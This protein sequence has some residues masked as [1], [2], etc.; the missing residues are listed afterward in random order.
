MAAHSSA[1]TPSRSGILIGVLVGVLAL[2]LLVLVGLAVAWLPRLENY[3]RSTPLG[4]PVVKGRAYEY[5]LTAPSDAWRLMRE[6]EARKHNERADRWLV[7]PD[8]DAHLLVVGLRAT[9]PAQRWDV[10]KAIELEVDA[11]RN[12][13]AKVEVLERAALES[14]LEDARLVHYRSEQ[15]RNRF[16]YVHAIF[17]AGE[18]MI[19]VVGWTWQKRFSEVEP[20]LRAAIAS[21]KLAQTPY[22]RARNRMSR[23]VRS[24]PELKA[25]DQQVAA[26]GEDASGAGQELVEKGLERLGPEHVERRL[27]ILRNMLRKSS[28]EVCG[29][30]TRGTATDEQAD[31]ALKLLPEKQIHEWMDLNVEAMLAELREARPTEVPSAEAEA[32]WAAVFKDPE[33]LGA[34]RIVTD[35]EGASD[36]ELCHAQRRL[37]DGVLAADPPHRRA[38]AAGWFR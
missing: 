16:E 11:V 7:R 3:A 5:E 31:R 21:L 35:P 4:N 27:R 29:A 10:E 37:L 9:P 23:R 2:A 32:A 8:L 1:K 25:F 22:E 24:E 34:W 30:L 13:G 28:D 20:E 18:V 12:T 6:H 26:R 14:E 15:K 36:P 38:I 17:S 19:Q 33:A